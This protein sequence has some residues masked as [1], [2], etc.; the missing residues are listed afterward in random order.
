MKEFCELYA[1]APLYTL[2]HKEES[3]RRLGILPDRV[4]DSF[5]S[6]LPFAGRKYRNYLSFMPLAIEQFDL[7]SYDV[8]ISSSHAVAKGV[9]TNY[10][11]LHLCYCYTPIRYAWD[12]YFQYLHEARLDKGIKSIVARCILHRIRMWDRIASERVD[13]FLAISEFI[14][15]RIEKVYGRKSTVIYPPVDVDRFELYTR[16]RDDF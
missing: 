15:H 3:L 2:L 6:K 5:I 13:H 10:D 1:D 9:L 4:H 7:S 14:A 8:I 16:I 12:L 11:Q